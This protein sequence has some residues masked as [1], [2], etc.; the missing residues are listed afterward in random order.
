M[1]C[2]GSA[3]QLADLAANWRHYRLHGRRKNLISRRQAHGKKRNGFAYR[4][5]DKPEV[6]GR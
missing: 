6:A 1:A 3:L 4:T 5:P 2:G